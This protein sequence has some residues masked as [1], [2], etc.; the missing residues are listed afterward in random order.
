[1]ALYRRGVGEHKLN[2]CKVQLVEKRQC[3]YGAVS[4]C[5]SMR[6]VASAGACVLKIFT[7]DTSP[8][9]VW[10]CDKLNLAV[11]D[12]DTIMLVDCH[13]CKR[14]IPESRNSIKSARNEDQCIYTYASWLATHAQTHAHIHIH[15]HA[16]THA[17]THRQTDTHTHTHTH[18]H[19]DAYTHTHT[20]IHIHTH[21]HIDIDTDTDTDTQTQTHTQTQT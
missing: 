17:S 20:D 6:V 18:I 9:G 2:E 12:P 5:A 19:T 11:G 13:T 8:S 16:H 10:Q 4:M 14:N 3:L 7:R 1:V 15:T 21:A